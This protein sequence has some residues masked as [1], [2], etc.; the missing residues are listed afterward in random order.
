M[1]IPPSFVKNT[2]PGGGAGEKNKICFDDMLY[3]KILT[4]MGR[5]KS[6]K[7]QFFR[8]LFN[9]HDFKILKMVFGEQ[10][11]NRTGYDMY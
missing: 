9:S 7:K 4:G 5:K 2:N 11:K 8:G 1:N 10:K 3:F 6:G